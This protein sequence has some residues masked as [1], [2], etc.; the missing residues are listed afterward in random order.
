MVKTLI[1]KFNLN[2]FWFL[3]Q[4]QP[5]AVSLKKKKTILY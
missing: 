4:P 1:E 2:V 5:L 3:A